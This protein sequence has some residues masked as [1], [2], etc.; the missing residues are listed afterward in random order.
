[1][2]QNALHNIGMEEEERIT[3]LPH[4]LGIKPAGNGLLATDDIK[5]AAGFFV[6]LPDEL[7]VHILEFL[8]PEEILGFRRSCKA[9]LALCLN[10]ETWKTKY[11]E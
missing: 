10:E 4:P 3:I 5:L 11:I 9:I 2:T 7:I 8:Q 6:R 1:M